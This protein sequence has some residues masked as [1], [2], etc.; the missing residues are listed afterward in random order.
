V[1]L[2]LLLRTDD[3]W[4]AACQDLLNLSDDLGGLDDCGALFNPATTKD[5][6]DGHHGRDVTDEGDDGVGGGLRTTTN[7]RAGGER[8]VEVFVGVATLVTTRRRIQRG[9]RRLEDDD[10]GPWSLS[11]LLWLSYDRLWVQVPSQRSLLL[12][13]LM[14]WTAL[15]TFAPP[16]LMTH[17]K[18]LQQNREQI[19]QCLVCH[20][21]LCPVCDNSFFGSDLSSFSRGSMS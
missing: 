18:A 4:I 6:N 12:V 17:S 19:Q 1:S 7:V 15:R 20:V 10:C 14:A 11:P 8:R 16:V 2:L 21:N 9:Q 13:R 5:D 3:A